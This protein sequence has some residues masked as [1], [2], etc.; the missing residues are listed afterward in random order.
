MQSYEKSISG[1]KFF[2]FFYVQKE[3]THLSHKTDKPHKT[4]GYQQLYN[5]KEKQ[6]IDENAY[7]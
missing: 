4:Y 3:M 6:I 2:L 7:I 1:Q 5:H